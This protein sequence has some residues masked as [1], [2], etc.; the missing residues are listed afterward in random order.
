M[1][2]SFFHACLKKRR[3][4]NGIATYITEQ[5]RLIDNFHDVVSHFVKHFRSYLGSPSSATG[6]IDLHCIEMGTKLSIDQKLL[7]LKPFSCK[8]IRAALF[9]IPITKSPGPDGFG[10]SF[11]KVLWQEIRDEVCSAIGQCFNTGHFPSELHETTLSLVPKVTNPSQAID[12]R[13]IAYCSTLYK[14]IAKL[15]CSRMALVLPDLI[16]LNHGAFIRGR[17]IAH[18]IMIFQDLIKNYRR[19]S[20]SPRCW[21]MVCLKNTSYSLLMNG[22][23]Q[24]TRSAVSIF[25]EVLVK[26]SATTGLSI[27]A[28]KSHIFFGGVIATERRIIAQEIQL[29]EGSFPLKLKLL[30]WT[31]RHLSFAG[32]MQL[33]HSVLFGLRNY[34]MSI[35]VLP[36][37]IVK[38]VEKLCRGFLWGIYGNRS[39]LHITSWQQVCLPKAY[40]GL[41]FRDGASWN[42]A[43]LAKYIWA[44]SEKPDILWVKW[45]N[46]IYLKGFNFYNYT[47]K[48]DSCWYWRKLCHLRGKFSQ[49]EILAAGVPGRFKPSKLYNS[50]LNQQLVGYHQEVWCKLTL[51]KHQ[52]LLWQVVN[53]HLLTRDNLIRFNLQVNNLL[54]PVC[55]GHNESHTHLFFECFLS[56]MILNLI[57]AWIGFKAWPSDF[58]SWVVWLP[59]G[60][61]GIISSILNLVVAAVIYSIWRNRNRCIFYGY[62]LIADSIAKDVIN[63]VKYRLYI[64]KNRKISLQDQLFIRKLQCN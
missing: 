16:Q 23:V 57:F 1:N 40:G 17:S 63:I 46:T 5:G 52:F 2:T 3:A 60:R 47:L 20:T 51:P 34:W 39:K 7:L 56:K 25:K 61:H 24:G 12:Y 9:G 50:T 21:I 35:F 55:G 8:E 29:P 42:K 53:A 33:I 49:T 44:I 43:I 4:E 45:I 26:F 58:N 59:S 27:N 6:R 32:Q 37:S 36:Q 18:N 15:L 11:F 48:P 28:N 10:S 19:T 30:S 14:C 54:C 22:R 38:E 62:S 13:P 31:S 41:G 64:V